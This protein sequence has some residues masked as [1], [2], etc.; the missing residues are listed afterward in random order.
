MSRFRGFKLAARIALLLSLCGWQPVCAAPTDPGPNIVVIVGDDWGFTDVG[1]YGSE[2]RTP[3]LDGLATSGMMFSNFHAA[4]ACSPTR[5]MLMTGVD[6][7]LNGLGAMQDLMPDEQRGKPGYLGHLADNVVTVATMLRDRGYHTSISGKWHLGDTPGTLPPMR[8]FDQSFIQGNGS[9]DNW[10]QKPWLPNETGQWYENG[11]PANLPKDFYSSQFIV[12]KAISY[13]GSGRP[14]GKP[15]FAYVGF[16]AVHIPVQA[17]RAFSDHYRGVY[18]GGWT[19]L[20][21]ARRKR[22][23]ALGLVPETADMVTMAST[24]DWDNLP[25]DD[26]R[27][28]ARRMEVYAGMAEAMDFHLGRLIAHLKHTGQYD[29]TVFVFLSDTGAEA[30]DPHESAL[31]RWWISSRYREDTA[32][33]GEKGAYSYIGPGWASAAVSPLNTYKQWAGEGS[34]RT[35]MIIAGVKGQMMGRMSASFAHVTDIV[36]TLL[37]IAGVAPHGDMYDGKAVEPLAGKSLLAVL[38]GEASETHGATQPIGYELQGNSALFRGG[39]KIVKNRKPVADG[40]WHLYYLVNDPG[41]VHDLKASMPDLF[42]SMLADYEAYVKRSNV[43]P[44]P[45]DYDYRSQGLHYALYHVLL[46]NA[47]PYLLLLIGG[48]ATL[49]F[50]RRRF[51]RA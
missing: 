25:A 29:N 23:V 17:P 15:F 19:A 26:K 2:I 34:L 39:Y 33:L 4:A 6:N 21:E 31:L 50:F 37:D 1:A 35:P 20:R 10:E 18:D 7:H 38:R 45:D 9:S 24:K 36:P 49:V 16:Q 12:D 3:N 13:I 47:W 11:K 41:E 42:Q 5:S 30:M 44:V 14:D 28:Q 40:A 43:L 46:P 27:D 22:A 51:R 48:V 8:G 32:S